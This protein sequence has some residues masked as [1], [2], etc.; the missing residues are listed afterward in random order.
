MLVTVIVRSMELTAR[1]R[2]RHQST[3][4]GTC[5]SSTVPVCGMKLMSDMRQVVLSGYM[6]LFRVVHGRKQKYTKNYCYALNSSELEVPDN[7]YCHVKCTTTSNV[8]SSNKRFYARILARNE[9]CD[10]MLNRIKIL[11]DVFRQSVE[12][13]SVVFHACSKLFVFVYS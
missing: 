4:S 5:R 7:G 11:S 3:R 9:I 2:S 8:V 10:M 1:F 13:R 12:L 6:V